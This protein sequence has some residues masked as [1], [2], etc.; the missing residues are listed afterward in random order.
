MA[1]LSINPNKS[2]VAVKITNTA[3]ATAQTK[4]AT[5]TAKTATATAT[6][7]ATV[8][9]KNSHNT[10]KDETT[11]STTMWKT[12]QDSLFKTDDEL[13]HSAE[14]YFLLNE[15]LKRVETKQVA[16]TSSSSNSNLNFKQRRPSSSSSI[17]KDGEDTTF[18]SP[19]ALE[20]LEKQEQ[21]LPDRWLDFFCIVG[22]DP[23][24][25]LVEEEKGGNNTSKSSSKVKG[26][27]VSAAPL[28]TNK[29][30]LLDRY[31]KEDR[32]DME[33]PEHLP[34][35]CFP[36][37]GCWP[38]RYKIRRHPGNLLLVDELNSNAKSLM[39]S[40]LPTSVATKSSTS[41]TKETK[42]KK[43]Q[44]MNNI[45]YHHNVPEPSLCNMVLTS[46]SGHRL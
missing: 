16:A 8:A 12:F 4:T 26:E 17:G 18:L 23:D 13:Q 15:E 24:A 14:S 35:F 40:L 39:K 29:P 25:R 34:T 20:E 45:K 6:S 10:K 42:K 3:K 46:G 36:N 2:D 19:S 5:T 7:T 27:S 31:P 28:K 9:E 33:F 32:L 38:L 41:T 30:V 1:F 37:G 22:L 43:K 44:A 21:S 11:K